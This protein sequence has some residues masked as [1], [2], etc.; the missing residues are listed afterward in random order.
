MSKV[1]GSGGGI[2]GPPPRRHY[3]PGPHPQCQEYPHHRSPPSRRASCQRSSY[4]PQFPQYPPCP[5]L[6]DEWRAG[7]VRE[8][9]VETKMEKSCTTSL[10]MS[11]NPVI[12]II[13]TSP[14]NG[15]GLS[16]LHLLNTLVTGDCKKRKR[17]RCMLRFAIHR[18]KKPEGGKLQTILGDEVLLVSREVGT[19]LRLLTSSPR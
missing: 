10:V 3:R 19:S 8:S 7:E 2:Q 12:P 1:G 13:S 11:G 14:N 6:L 16:V 9:F 5:F 4:R 17:Y 15:L 18:P